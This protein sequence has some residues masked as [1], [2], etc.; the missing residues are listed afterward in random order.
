MAQGP[1]TLSGKITDS[2]G[3]PVSGAAVS[4]RNT[5]TNQTVRVQSD[6]AGSYTAAN[7]PPGEYDVS[8]SSDG[9]APSTLKTIVAANET[10]KVDLVLGAG[11]QSSTAPSL[12]DLGLAPDQAQGNA[13]EQARLDKRSHMLLIHQRLGLI[14]A[15]PL[16]AT[17]ITSGGA[18]GHNSS[19]S[20]RDLHAT[21]GGI[22]AGMY[23]STA[24]F[25]LFA[26]KLHDTPVRG[27]IR[28]H[29]ALAWIHGP[30][31]V[32]TPILGAMA[33]DQ[34][35]AGEKVHGIAKAH[36]AAAWVTGVAYGAAILSV[37]IRF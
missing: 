3:A 7:L 28:L 4:I 33:L 14:T 5:A 15:A 25:A 18:A 26:P 17:L 1:G 19:A 34:K 35:N 31:M 12:G 13:A 29:R 36:G 9:L 8:A 2:S 21:L 30:G 24:Y 10:E 11:S 32:I 6:A 37:S 16:L 23:L 20:G 27:P 22:T